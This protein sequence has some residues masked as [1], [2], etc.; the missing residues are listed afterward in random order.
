MTIR[1][2]GPT[3]LSLM[4]AT[5]LLTGCGA[6]GTASPGVT[7][8]DSAPESSAGSDEVDLSSLCDIYA[9]TAQ[10]ADLSDLAEVL[11]FP[12]PRP[13]D[14]FFTYEST[15]DGGQAYVAAYHGDGVIP[16]W[17]DAAKAGGWEA[18]PDSNDLGLQLRRDEGI[19]NVI[20]LPDPGSMGID[21]DVPV[22]TVSIEL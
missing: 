7:A 8:T 19:I 11:G 5:A 3:A 22:I 21:T 13:A 6:A 9:T 17:S 1:L 12:P 4:L 15:D 18:T 14:C 20:T 10:P 2:L 16:A